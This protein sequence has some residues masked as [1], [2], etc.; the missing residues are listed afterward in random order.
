MARLARLEA[1]YARLAPGIPLPAAVPRPVDGQLA[2]AGVAEGIGEPGAAAAPA[3]RL[4][5]RALQVCLAVDGRRT[6]AELAAGYG[7][8]RTARLLRTL[9]ESGVL[10]LTVPSQWEEP[11]AA[12]DALT[13]G[14][15]VEVS[16]T[17]SRWLF[18]TIGQYAGHALIFAALALFASLIRSA[19]GPADRLLGFRAP[20]PQER[21]TAPAQ[22]PSSALLIAK[23]RAALIP[24][25]PA[26]DATSTTVPT[27]A[28]T[29][30]PTAVM[31]GVDKITARVSRFD[32]P[33]EQAVT[34]GT[35]SIVVRDCEKSAPEERPENAAFVE[36]YENRP[37]EA[38]R[39]LFSGWMFSS[40][41]ALSAL[42]HPVYD[43]NLLECKG[44]AP[45]PPPPAPTTPKS[46]GRSRGKTAR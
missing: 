9:V 18:H 12:V 30:E 25:T 45:P 36:I 35:L 11:P 31:Q 44:V 40:S 21:L 13:E 32:T 39:R 37:G 16:S 43:V 19:A 3:R 26:A 23:P 33:V 20:A 29:A 38:R 2:V 27:V 7:M 15:N 8:A 42:E 1:D 14:K 10:E 17:G 34:F 5:R 6:V 22:L 4:D 46:P 41:P 28:P 24:A